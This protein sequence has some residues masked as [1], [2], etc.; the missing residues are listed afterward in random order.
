MARQHPIAGSA[1]S[2]QNDV[3]LGHRAVSM[4]SARN[5]TST[6]RA[7]PVRTFSWP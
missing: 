4:I 7:A 1:V 5:F 6:I 3:A 2:F